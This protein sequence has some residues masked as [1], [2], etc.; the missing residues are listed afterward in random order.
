MAGDQYST[1]GQAWHPRGA[2]EGS[3]CY[4]SWVDG[5]DSAG[6][7]H[8]H[9][10]GL[11]R[12]IPP[13][14]PVGQQGGGTAQ[15]GSAWVWGGCA[16]VCVTVLSPQAFAM[17]HAAGTSSSPC[18][19]PSTC[20]SVRMARWSCPARPSARPPVRPA[21]SWSVSVAGPT[22]SSAHLT[23]S[24]RDARYGAGGGTHRG[25]TPPCCHGLQIP[26]GQRERGNAGCPQSSAGD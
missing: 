6:A 12:P 22:S 17:P 21:P 7:P 18:S 5:A 15:G 26:T 3:G 8:H 24:L 19:A 2:I 13:H 23:A 4:V 1:W 10:R 25:E 11:P 20:P 16:Y 14:V 9:S